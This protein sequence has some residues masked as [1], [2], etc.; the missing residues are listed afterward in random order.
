[1]LAS[2]C[3]RPKTAIILGALWGLVVIAYP[4]NGQERDEKER[5]ARG[6]EVDAERVQERLRGISS[7]GPAAEMRGLSTLQLQPT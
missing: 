5:R 1:M 4:A 7:P 6:L 3:D 2:D